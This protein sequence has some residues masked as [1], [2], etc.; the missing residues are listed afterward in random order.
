MQ[1]NCFRFAF[2]AAGGGAFSAAFAG[3]FSI[4]IVPNATLSANPTA[5]AAFNRAADRWEAI[6]IDPV[7]VQIDA[8][9]AA[10]GAGV[11]GSTSSVH[12][13]SSFT[14]LR[15]QMV[16]DA[17]DEGAS[18]AIIAS[19][20]TSATFTAV[21]PGGYSL[22]SDMVATKANLKALGF[23]GLDAAFGASDASITFNTGFAFDFDNSDGVGAGL[24]DFETVALHEI[25]HALGFISA[26]D[27]VDVRLAANTP[28]AINM[29][30]L[31]LFRFQNNVA[32]NDPAN[33]G[34]FATMPR[35]LVTG[36]DSIFDDGTTEYRFSTGRLTGDGQQASHWKDNLGLGT[37]DPTLGA[38]ELFDISTADMRAFDLIGYDLA[39]VPEP[40]TMVA[41]GVGVAAFLR[42]RKKA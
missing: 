1:R 19:L 27:D 42:R 25:G 7:S 2:L 35:Y 9:L 6:F 14:T 15:N 22:S 33:A 29:N 41:L 31:D 18:N 11:L 30:P 37:M 28:G 32:G 24:F 8:G 10:L 21:V 36:G 4:N 39:A 17:A 16:V 5:L 38:G 20:P 23:G 12:L 13:S 40:G 26:V 3:P 34:D